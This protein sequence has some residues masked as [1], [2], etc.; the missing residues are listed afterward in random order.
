VILKSVTWITANNRN[1]AI[2]MIAILIL[3][4]LL[5]LI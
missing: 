2:F 5:M 3:P 1:L 4:I